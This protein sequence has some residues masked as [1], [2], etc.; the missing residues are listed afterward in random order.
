MHNTL[1]PWRSPSSEPPY[2]CCTGTQMSVVRNKRPM[3]GSTKTRRHRA[4]Q[5]HSD[6]FSWNEPFNIYNS[7][8]ET[9]LQRQ[10]SVLNSCTCPIK[11]AIFWISCVFRSCFT[12]VIK[13]TTLQK[14]DG[15][16]TIR[17]RRGARHQQNHPALATKCRM[18]EISGLWL[19]IQT[20]RFRENLIHLD[21]FSW[22]EPFRYL[23]FNRRDNK[24][25]A[26]IPAV[27]PLFAN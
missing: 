19:E 8:E 20:R 10:E 23:Q 16:C 22:N 26:R 12:Q 1:S 4:N 5:I 7:T 6:A 14:S 9:T 13:T 21:A 17:C 25:N 27:S 15:A 11:I 18:S 3:A 24:P 2:R